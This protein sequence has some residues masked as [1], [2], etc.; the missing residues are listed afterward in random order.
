MHGAMDMDADGSVAI[1]HASHSEDDDV[2]EQP[3]SNIRLA[4]VP[5]GM[6]VLMVIGV[7]GFC[8]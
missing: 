5:I 4:A 7:F 2:V 8:P 1:L 3:V 6:K